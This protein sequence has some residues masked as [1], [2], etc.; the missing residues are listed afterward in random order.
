MI[1]ISKPVLWKNLSTALISSSTKTAST[2][3]Y[4][5]IVGSHMVTGRLKG[6]PLPL[7]SPFF[8][9]PF[10]P[11]T[12]K[13]NNAPTVGSAFFVRTYATPKKQ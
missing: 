9:S 10:L 11:S 5:T 7:T 4:H 2:N 6:Q 3:K 12:F 1:I 13:A 8:F